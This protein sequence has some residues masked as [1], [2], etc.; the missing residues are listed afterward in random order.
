[1]DHFEISDQEL[2]DRLG[3]PRETIWRWHREQ[4]RLNYDKIKEIAGGLGIPPED[5]YRP[6]K[7]ISLDAIIKEAPELRETAAEIIHTLIRQKKK[8]K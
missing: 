6:P 4:R 7:E 5:L 3:R 8:P 2:G 1:M